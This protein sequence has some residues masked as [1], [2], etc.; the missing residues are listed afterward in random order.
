MTTAMHEPI[1]VVGVSAIMPDAPD[2]AT[3]WANIKAG[4]YCISNVR[5]SDGIRSSSTTP[6]RTLRRIRRTPVSAGGSASSPGSRSRGSCR[7]RRR[8]A[9]RWT[10]A[11]G[12]P[13]R[14]PVQRCWTPGGRTGRWTRSES[15]SSSAAPS[16]ATSSTG[17]TCA[18]TPGVR[19]GAVRRAVVCGAAGA[20]ARSCA[21]RDQRLF[22]RRDREDHRG[23]HARRTREHHR[24]PGGEPVQLPRPQLHR[25]RGVRLGAGRHVAAVRGLQAGDFDAVIT[26]GV[27]H[28]MDASGFVKFCKIGA[29]SA[30]GTRP[31]DAGADGFVMGEGARCSSSSDCP[32]PSAMVTGSTRCCSA[33]PAPATGAARGS[34]PP[35]RLGSGWRSSAPG[36]SPASTRR[37]PPASRGTVRP[38]AS[39]TQRSWPA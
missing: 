4:R 7:S 26:G 22:S 2:A 10:T 17:A 30:T 11:R 15:P 8:S 6:T 23:Q 20:G 25:R 9:P 32:T 3:F 1:A 19:P 21:R 13:W 24:R 28:N 35:T 18:S 14:V 34:P 5:R 33:W 12:G 39:A 27:D 31:F 38:R 36:R 37:W 29:L 16:A